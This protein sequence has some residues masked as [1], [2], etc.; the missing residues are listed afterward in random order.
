MLVSIWLSQSRKY[1]SPCCAKIAGMRSPYSSSMSTSTSSKGIPNCC[2]RRRPT[3]LFPLPESPIKNT[4]RIA[5]IVPCSG[6]L[7]EFL[8]ANIGIQDIDQAEGSGINWIKILLRCNALTYKGLHTIIIDF[9][10]AP[11]GED[12]LFQLPCLA[13]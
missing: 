6:E 13:I 12:I 1:S 5:P 8:I 11:K 9:E 10:C 4:C 2:A 3:V 7:V